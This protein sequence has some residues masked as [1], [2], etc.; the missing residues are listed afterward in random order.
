MQEINDIRTSPEA[1]QFVE[2][3]CRSQGPY[4]RRENDRTQV[5]YDV[6]Y[7]IVG[8]VESGPASIRDIS[9]TGLQLV[10]Q[11]ELPRGADVLLRISVPD[12]NVDTVWLSA[13]VLYTSADA[14]G[15]LSG[16]ICQ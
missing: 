9:E 8:S 11:R 15:Y 4:E 7:H 13:H 6:E 1:G 5:D 2:D 16:C 14:E 10:T 12:M 3:V